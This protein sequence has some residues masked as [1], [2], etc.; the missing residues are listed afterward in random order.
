MNWLLLFGSLC[1]AMVL[2]ETGHAVMAWIFGVRVEKLFLFMEVKG[3]ALFRFKTRH[4]EFGVGLLPI[5]SMVQLSGLRTTPKMRP[6]RHLFVMKPFMARMMIVLGGPL[7]N[8]FTTYLAIRISPSSPIVAGLA[9]ASAYLAIKNLLPF[10]NTDGPCLARMVGDHFYL[11]RR[12]RRVV[13]VVLAVAALAWWIPLCGPLRAC[14]S[15][16]LHG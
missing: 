15:L 9:V 16:L 1:A 6:E 13:N 2:H 14:I 12:E 7:I 5:G 10:W 3:R 8:A 11:S 4:T